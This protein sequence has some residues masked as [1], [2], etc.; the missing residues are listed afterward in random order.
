MTTPTST[1]K[2]PARDPLEVYL[3]QLEERDRREKKHKRYI[4]ACKYTQLFRVSY[5]MLN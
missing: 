3:E 2:A 4:D 1:S 5:S